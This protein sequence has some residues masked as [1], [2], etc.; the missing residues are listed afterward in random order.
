MDREGM[1]LLYELRGTSREFYGGKKGVPGA[2]SG[3]GV[4]TMTR[5]PRLP[6]RLRPQSSPS[7]LSFRRYWLPGGRTMGTLMAGEE[8]SRARK[9]AGTRVPTRQTPVPATPGRVGSGH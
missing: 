5:P 8:T 2:G 3:R 7:P 9:G 1:S 6:G 4:A